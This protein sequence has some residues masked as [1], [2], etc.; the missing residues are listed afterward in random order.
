MAKLVIGFVELLSSQ[1]NASLA[2][3]GDWV[4]PLEDFPQLSFFL[5]YNLNLQLQLFQELNLSYW[6]A[7]LLATKIFSQESSVERFE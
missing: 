6:Q 4:N 3:S 1:S 2:V 5:P 7:W